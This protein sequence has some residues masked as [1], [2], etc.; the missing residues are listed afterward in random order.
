[1]SRFYKIYKTKIDK[2]DQ[3]D[4]SKILNISQKSVFRWGM[5]YTKPSNLQLVAIANYFDVTLNCLDDRKR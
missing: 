3:K 4:F 5:W 1:M 2:L